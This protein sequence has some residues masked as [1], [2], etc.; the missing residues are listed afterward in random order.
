MNNWLLELH[1]FWISSAKVRFFIITSFFDKISHILSKIFSLYIF[2]TRTEQ[3]CYGFQ[4]SSCNISPPKIAICFHPFCITF[5]CRQNQ[6]PF[7]NKKKR[8]NYSQI[9]LYVHVR[10][11]TR[12]AF[13]IFWGKLLRPACT[14]TQ[15]LRIFIQNLPFTVY[16][17][18]FWQAINGLCANFTVNQ[19]AVSIKFNIKLIIFTRC[20]HEFTRRGKNN[21]NLSQL[22]RTIKTFGFQKSIWHEY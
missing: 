2:K 6:F 8:E 11:L 19:F 14:R 7:K 22:K 16:F 15:L 18:H 10:C 1:V 17:F 9:W 4:F 3:V 20:L 12:F 21:N 13:L 5:P